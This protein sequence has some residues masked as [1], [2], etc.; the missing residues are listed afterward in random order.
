MGALYYRTVLRDLKAP[1]IA[2][3]PVSAERFQAVKRPH[4]MRI[5]PIILSAP[6]TFVPAHESRTRCILRCAPFRLAPAVMDLCLARLPL[7]A[8]VRMDGDARCAAWKQSGTSKT[9]PA[10]TISCVLCCIR[11][12]EKA[13]HVCIACELPVSAM[14]NRSGNFQDR[15]SAV[16]MMY[17]A[18]NGPIRHQRRQRHLTNVS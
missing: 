12:P 18:V 16:I 17:D 15:S 11:V 8:A 4:P 9:R 7:Q 13:R 1:S 5:S 6:E 3:K 2:D 10:S 14:N